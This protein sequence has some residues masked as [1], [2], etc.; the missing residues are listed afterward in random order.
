MQPYDLPLDQLQT[1]RPAL[2]RKD[3]FA[4]F[5][6]ATKALLDQEPL[7]YELAPLTY[8]ADGVRLYR[9]SYRGFGGARIQ[10]YFAVPDKPGAHP[11]LILYHGY[12]WCF[13]GGIHDVVNWALHGYAAFGMLVRGQHS[14]EDNSWHFCVII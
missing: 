1:Y 13:D 10:G 8:P 12:D 7:T 4:D 14:S 3:D 9:L 5:W 6:E 2:T 11:G